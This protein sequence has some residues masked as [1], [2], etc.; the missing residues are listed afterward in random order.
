M[1]VRMLTSLAGEP[2]Y[3]WGQ[4]VDI[5]PAV[6]QAWIAEGYAVAVVDDHPVQPAETTMA[7]DL[8]EEAVTLP[9]KRKGR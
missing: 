7:S 5:S 8:R 1:R 2:G 6:A 9:R 3:W 4:V